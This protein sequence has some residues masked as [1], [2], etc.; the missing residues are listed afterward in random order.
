MAAKEETKTMPELA[1]GPLFLWRHPVETVG[2][3]KRAAATGNTYFRKPGMPLRS[4]L[5]SRVLK[6]QCDAIIAAGASVEQVQYGDLVSRTAAVMRSLCQFLQIPYDPRLATLEGA[7]RSAVYE[8]KHHSLLRQDVIVAGPRPDVLDPGLRA[9][10]DHDLTL[11]RE[12]DARERRTISRGPTPSF[13][14]RRLDQ[15]RYRLYRALDACTRAAFC[16]LPIPLLRLY[17]KAKAHAREAKTKRN[18]RQT[19]PARQLRRNELQGMNERERTVG[20]KS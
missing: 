13:A 19:I 11:W 5:G 7:D 9:K 8:G 10:I 1:P 12:S 17:R 2:A 4:L 18:A 15:L 16:F 20:N 6:R 3:T 14:Q